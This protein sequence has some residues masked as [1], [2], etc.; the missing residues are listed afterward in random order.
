MARAPRP[1]FRRSDSFIAV[2]PIRV[3]GQ[4]IAPGEPVVAPLHILRMYHQRRRIGPVGHAW[5][6]QSLAASSGH[7]LPF[8]AEPTE[9]TEPQRP[10]PVRDGARWVVE[11][12]DRTF[13]SKSSAMAYIDGQAKE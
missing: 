1:L 13:R 8:V 11:G 9:P 10:E 2:R 5:T 4:E 12:S 7:P 6:E 3:G